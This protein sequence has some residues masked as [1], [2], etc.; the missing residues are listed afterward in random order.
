MKF[1]HIILISLILIF[2]VLITGCSEKCSQ[3]ESVTVTPISFEKIQGLPNTDYHVTYEITNKGKETEKNLMIIFTMN[4]RSSR[5]F[6]KNESETVGQLNPSE[7]KLMVINF[8]SILF[9]LDQKNFYGTP[10]MK[11]NSCTV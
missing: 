7:S 1:I 5:D 8:S 4:S 2:S 10:Y 6:K 3:V 11:S 9:G